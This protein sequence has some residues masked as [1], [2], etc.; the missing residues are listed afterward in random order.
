MTALSN[1]LLS[2]VVCARSRARI[3]ALRAAAE[4][5]SRTPEEA[6]SMRVLAGLFEAEHDSVNAVRAA[7]LQ[8]T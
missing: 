8:R 6:D 1:D 5:P 4:D 2:R 3:D 7:K